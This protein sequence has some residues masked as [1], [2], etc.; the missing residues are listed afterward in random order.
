MEVG[1]LAA[2]GTADIRRLGV[3]P[4][5]MSAVLGAP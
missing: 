4:A 3:D 5:P 1:M 2:H